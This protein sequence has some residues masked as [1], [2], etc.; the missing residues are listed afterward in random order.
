LVNIA[1]FCLFEDLS[2]STRVAP[3]MM[4]DMSAITTMSSMS[5]NHL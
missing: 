1:N 5:V 3:S 4:M 2:K